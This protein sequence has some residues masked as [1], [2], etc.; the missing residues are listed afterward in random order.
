MYVFR[1]HAGFD[2][3]VTVGDL[4]AQQRQ[5]GRAVTQAAP[6]VAVIGAVP[7]FADGQIRTGIDRMRGI[8]GPQE[9]PELDSFEGGAFPEVVRKGTR[10][11]AGVGRKLPDYLSEPRPD[12]L[13]QCLEFIGHGP[14][15]VTAELAR[16]VPPRGGSDARAAPATH[17]AS[18]P[19]LVPTARD[20]RDSAGP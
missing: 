1:I 19:R 11:G 20:D 8:I 17:S 4:G 12:T 14:D 7:E 2:V 13:C 10:V 5:P 18:P 16:A 15:P 6:A 3:R 9:G